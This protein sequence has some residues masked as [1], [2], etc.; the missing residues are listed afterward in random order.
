MDA[1]V[2]VGVGGL[3]WGRAGVC[4]GTIDGVTVVEACVGV[5]SLHW[6]PCDCGGD[7]VE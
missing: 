7:A 1:E 5:N 2:T 4:V 3:I 6:V